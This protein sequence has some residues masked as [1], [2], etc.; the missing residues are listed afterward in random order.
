MH[1]NTL[2]T[3]YLKH[4]S[5]IKKAILTGLIVIT[6]AMGLTYLG[7]RIWFKSEI[8]QICNHATSLYAGDKVGA[9]I[10][11]LESDKQSLKTKNNAIWALGKLNDQR[12][13]PVLKKLQT[14]KEC[15]HTRYVCQR[16]LK[17]AI[18]NLE[19]RGIDILTFK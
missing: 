6:A 13:L 3:D 15:D 11:L 7:F 8:N 17:K 12:A 9:L 1:C 10:G 18:D 5:I 19:G 14:G 16:E 4:R 2:K